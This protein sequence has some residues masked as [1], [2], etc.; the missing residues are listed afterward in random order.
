[1]KLRTVFFSI[2]LVAGLYIAWLLFNEVA[3]F[4]KIYKFDMVHGGVS[5]LG[6]YSSFAAIV[7]YII[8]LIT[9]AG[10]YFLF[11]AQ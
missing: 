10:G 8:C 1:M 3:T 7:I 4:V 5:G 6:L 11:R 2:G 9:L